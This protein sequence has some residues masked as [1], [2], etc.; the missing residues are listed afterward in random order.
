VGRV[1]DWPYSSFHAYV[2]RGLLP[3]DWAG[4]VSETM[5]TFGERKA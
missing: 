4:G 1:R 2:R 5:M 3:P